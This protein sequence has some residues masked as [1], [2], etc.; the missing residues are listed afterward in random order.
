MGAILSLAS[1][2]VGGFCVGV[3][4]YKAVEAV[5]RTVLQLLFIASKTAF[6]P[7]YQVGM[8]S[9]VDCGHLPSGQLKK[10]VADV[11]AAERTTKFPATLIVRKI[12]R[13]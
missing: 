2:R 10:V 12:I 13:G 7:F 8:I 9:Q 5:V 11:P 3:G 4:E 1:G 6:F